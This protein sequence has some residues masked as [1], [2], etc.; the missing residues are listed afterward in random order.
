MTPP[1]KRAAVEGGLTKALSPAGRR[2]GNRHCG[3]LHPRTAQ[4]LSLQL[5]IRVACANQ[6]R[7]LG[8]IPGVVGTRHRN[9]R[10]DDRHPVQRHVLH[11]LWPVDVFG[12]THGTRF[13]TAL[14]ANRRSSERVN[15]KGEKK[16]KKE[17][18]MD[19]S[20]GVVRSQCVYQGFYH[21]LPVSNEMSSGCFY[22]AYSGS[23]TYRSQF[24]LPRKFSV[25][26][27]CC[28][29]LI[30][31]FAICDSKQRKKYTIK[32]TFYCGFWL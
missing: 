9:A 27:N 5:Q 29:L 7:V 15:K 19:H 13:T 20:I 22:N 16:K 3:T 10:L 11:Y 24:Q 4:G 12:L 8:P 21:G 26:F 32:L 6:Y 14:T 25:V 2:L 18:K 23:G 28:S 17:K 30:A 1:L 31:S